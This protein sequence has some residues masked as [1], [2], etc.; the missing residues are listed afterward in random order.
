MSFTPLLYNYLTNVRSGPDCFPLVSSGNLDVNHLVLKEREKSIAKYKKAQRRMT[1]FLLPV[2]NPFLKYILGRKNIYSLEVKINFGYKEG[3]ERKKSWNRKRLSREILFCLSPGRNPFLSLSLPVINCSAT[4]HSKWSI[5]ISV[6]IL[7]FISSLKS[8]DL[9]NTYTMST[10]LH[11]C[12]H[13][14]Y[15]MSVPSR[16]SLTEKF[17]PWGTK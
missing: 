5:F 7:F 10:C 16:A 2:R 4:K 11:L 8:I 14:V 6:F 9:I 15:T 3:L 17:F 13:Y 1:V 12:L